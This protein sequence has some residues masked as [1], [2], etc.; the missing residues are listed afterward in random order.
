[1]T[2]LENNYGVYMNIENYMREINQKIK[3]TH[4]YKDLFDFM[5]DDI[6]FKDEDE[7]Q[8]IIKSYKR[9]KQKNILKLLLILK[10][11]QKLF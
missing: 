1:M 8:T 11:T 5:K 2:E 10:V 7:Y 6:I 9:A 3:N 4:C